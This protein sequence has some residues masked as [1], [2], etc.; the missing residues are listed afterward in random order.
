MRVTIVGAG[1]DGLSTAWSLTRRGHQVTLLDQGPILNP[2]AASGDEHRLM[3]RAYGEADGYARLISEALEAWDE[4]WQDL[5]VSHYANRGVIAINQ[6]PND[7]GAASHASLTRGGYA[8][9]SF[10]PEQ[11]AD[12]V[13]LAHPPMHAFGRAA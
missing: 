1:I 3:R 2:L 13:R 4:M 6:Y 5:G 10:T 12:A 11:A 8:F 9:D 7:G